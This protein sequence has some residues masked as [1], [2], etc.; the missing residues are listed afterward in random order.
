[1]ANSEL[2]LTIKFTYNFNDF[3]DLAVALCIIQV[4]K[5]CELNKNFVTEFGYKICFNFKFSNVTIRV[6]NFKD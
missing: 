2:R 6:A 1:M 3:K 4:Q 5:L